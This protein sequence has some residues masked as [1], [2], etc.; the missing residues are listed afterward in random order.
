MTFGYTFSKAAWKARRRRFKFDG[1]VPEYLRKPKRYTRLH[2]A[3]VS[4]V[5]NGA[6]YDCTVRLIKREDDIMKRQQQSHEPFALT[7]VDNKLARSVINAMDFDRASKAHSAGKLTNVEYADIVRGL[8]NVAYPNDRKALSKFLAVNAT[9]QAAKVAA[10]YA[11]SQKPIGPDDAHA[12]Q[13]AVTAVGSG[14][15]IAPS[16]NPYRSTTMSDSAANSDGVEAPS[17]SP[18]YNKFGHPAHIGL[19]PHIISSIARE[20]FNNDVIAAASYIA[21]RGREM[22]PG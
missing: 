12:R 18:S 16:H 7:E 3:E 5:E 19:K 22:F 21:A 13:R 9:T 8:A 10:D 20:F 14:V 6:G 15:G 2:L 4:S 1:P 17:I 11:A